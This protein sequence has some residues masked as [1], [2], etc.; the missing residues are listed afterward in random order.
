MESTNTRT[1]RV[2]AESYLSLIQVDFANLHD[3]VE[4]IAVVRL[5][6]VRCGGSCDGGSHLFYFFR[7][8]NGRPSLFWSIETG[9]LAYECGLISVNRNL[10]WKYSKP[11]RLK[12]S[13]TKGS[14]IQESYNPDEVKNEGQ[15]GGKFIANNL[16]RFVFEFNKGRFV[17]RSTEVLPNPNPDVRNY[18][19]QVSIRD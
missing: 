9:S 4:L 18:E 14:S 5:L 12:D 15:S 7:A 8:H 1:R 3:G 2:E 13:Q 6:L 11:A 16:T 19:Q 17:M 10:R